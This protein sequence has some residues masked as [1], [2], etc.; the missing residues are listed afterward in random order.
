MRRPLGFLT[1][2]VLVSLFFA[3]CNSFAKVQKSKDYDYKLTKAEEY[4]EK[5]KYRFAQVLYEELFPIFK[6]T[7]K[8]EVLYYKYAYCFYNQGFYREAESLFKGYLEVFP[9]SDKAE[10][11]DFQRAF[12]YYKL[13]PKLELEQV[14]TLRAM[15]MMQ[16]FI[17]THPESER[18]KDAT[19]IIDKSRQ[20]LEMKEYRGAQLFYN[21]GEFRAAALSF[22]RLLDHFPESA[23]GDQYKL[24]VIKSYFRFAKM[25]I[26]EKQEERFEKVVAEYQDFIDRFPESPLGKEA[27]SYH[28][29]SINQLNFIRNEQTSSSTGR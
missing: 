19:E 17:S 5:K 2:L 9:N 23:S 16:T 4:F 3:A 28:E 15:S 29:Q 20:K 8:F 11:V 25:S 10:E 6:G 1:G 26:A 12:C 14:N 21:I 22:S 18:V 13:S 24:M 27:A 7:A